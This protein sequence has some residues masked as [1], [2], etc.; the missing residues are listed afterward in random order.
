[1]QPLLSD[2]L[3][4]LKRLHDVG[5]K[6]AVIAGGA[7]RDAFFNRYPNDIDIFVQA[8]HT[9]GENVL[10]EFEVLDEHSLTKLFQLT[11]D[12]A[13]YISSDLN[14][15]FDLSIFGDQDSVEKMG[16]VYDGREGHIHGVYSVYKADFE[17]EYQIVVLNKPT[18]EYVT[19]YFDVGL[20][21][22]YC[23]GQRMRYTHEFLTDATNKTL[24]IC[25]ELTA[26]E[27]YYTLDH[28]VEKLKRRFPDF[29]VVDLLKDK[30]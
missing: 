19:R 24:T 14:N 3:W 21:M 10:S 13:P 8:P 17:T 28:H 26:N 25:G 23:D 16:A 20:C 15:I 1:M 29:T 22:C 9:S 4:M 18:V 11:T 5:Y 30:F 7:V 2:D 6:S 27:Y 12:P